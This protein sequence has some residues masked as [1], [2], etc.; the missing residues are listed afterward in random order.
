VKFHIFFIKMQNGHSAIKIA[1]ISNK[2]K[3]VFNYV[4]IPVSG[5]L[6]IFTSTNYI[7][8][9]LENLH[10]FFHYIFFRHQNNEQV[11]RLS[12]SIN[13]II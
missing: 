11:I 5:D 6:S 2:I 7:S 3:A 4:C 13:S 10:K 12:D 9:F 8:I 1:N